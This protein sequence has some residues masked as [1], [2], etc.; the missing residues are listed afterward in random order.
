MLGLLVGCLLACFVGFGW[1]V[2]WF[3]L[4]LACC[5]KQM[6]LAPNSS[7]FPQI[8]YSP[9]TPD[10]AFEDA[11]FLHLFLPIFNTPLKQVF[12][13]TPRPAPICTR[14]VAE[15]D[16]SWGPRSAPK[17]GRDES[18]QQIGV[19]L[20]NAQQSYVSRS[21]GASSQV[22]RSQWQFFP[23][24][25]EH[26]LVRLWPQPRQC[27]CVLGCATCPQYLELSDTS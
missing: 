13:G 20:S 23:R 18:Q 3:V 17:N 5:K 27:R 26:F 9:Q 1:L 11:R 12:C 8:L 10:F 21:S 6:L 4:Y 22:V 19:L 16:P 2:G 14:A 7:S 15:Q 25:D 24:T